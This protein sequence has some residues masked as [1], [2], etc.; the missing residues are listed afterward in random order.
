MNPV[1]KTVRIDLAHPGGL[2]FLSRVYAV[3]GDA[4]SRFVAFELY[5]NGEKYTPPEGTTAIVRYRKDDGTGGNYEVLPDGSAAYTI[6][7]NMLTVTLAPQ[8]C[9][10]P[11]LVQLAVGL[12]S[13]N[14]EINT[15]S[16]RVVV[17]PNPGLTYQSESH[18]K[19]AGT[20]ADSGWEPNMY[21]G[22]DDGGNVTDLS[23]DKTLN[24]PGRAADAKATGDAIRGVRDDLASE[25]SRAEQA[26][27][28]LDTR[29]A[30]LESCGFVVVDGK[31]CM[32]YVKS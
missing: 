26:E 27:Q 32:K 24:Q 12:I 4:Y 11:G 17:Q 18:V 1:T 5:S 28:A 16:V 9:I 3:Q 30:A 14:A 13:G 29:T 2:D 22:T 21:L 25:I 8:V 31:V 20:V 23:T 6:N 19:L 15:F 7:G 10:V